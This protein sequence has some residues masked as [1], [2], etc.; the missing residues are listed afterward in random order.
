ML[1]GYS[2]NAEQSFALNV[3]MNDSIQLVTLTGKGGNREDIISFGFS[4]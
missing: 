3:L 1:T 2:R 4:F